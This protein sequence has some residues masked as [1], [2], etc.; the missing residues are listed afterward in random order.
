MAGAHR[1]GSVVLAPVPVLAFAVRAVVRR[2]GVIGH[3][4]RQ[5]DHNPQRFLSE[6]VRVR[7]RRRVLLAQLAHEFLTRCPERAT[8]IRRTAV[9]AGLSG[10]SWSQT[11][12][13]YAR[14]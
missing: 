4:V 11:K 10:V 5:Q 3:A 7:V 6:G 12:S 9:A 1:T 8:D 14:S 13:V 2:V